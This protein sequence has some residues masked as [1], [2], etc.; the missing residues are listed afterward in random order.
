MG[1]TAQAARCFTQSLSALGCFSETLK[2]GCRWYTATTTVLMR[3]T[4]PPI[5]Y[6][7]QWK[8]G[9][10]F[11]PGFFPHFVANRP[12]CDR[13]R[14][15]PWY[16]TSPDRSRR[17]RCAPLD[18]S[19]AGHL[20]FCLLRP[21]SCAVSGAASLQRYALVVTRQGNRSV[22]DSTDQGPM[23]W[24]RSAMLVLH[25]AFFSTGPHR[26]FFSTTGSITASGRAASASLAITRPA[27][28]PS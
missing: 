6:P 23:T 24:R 1:S 16:S 12:E 8:P 26:S 2:R 9:Q 18:V 25:S 19:L 4:L 3:V 22:G 14:R 20:R 17:A 27:G 5:P 21:L 7:D 11:C 13:Q 28:L 10:V 15:I